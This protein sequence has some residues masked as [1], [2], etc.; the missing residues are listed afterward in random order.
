MRCRQAV[1]DASD[2]LPADCDQPTIDQALDDF[3]EA[4]RVRLAAT[5]YR[6][7]SDVVS[8]LRDALNNYSYQA[9]SDAERKRW[10]AAFEAGDEAA[11]CKLFG[12]EKIVAELG[13]FLDWF[14]VRKVIA[15]DDL[16]RA[17]GTVIKKLVRWLHAQGH[18]NEQDA[19]DAVERGNGAARDLP[20]ASRLTDALS[21]LCAAAP[22]IDVDDVADEDWV[23]DTLPITRIEAGKLWLGE[24]G[25]LKL[26]RRATDNARIG[27]EV[28]VVIAHH[29]G[30]WHLLENGFVYP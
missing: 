17:A 21:D 4:Q 11:F 7:Y 23:E 30:R 15:S 2:V 19:S 29:R 10:E 6:R 24:R 12:P 14:M 13:G 18:V 28:W 27:W 25:P 1:C 5:T 9:L 16:L 8:L 20:A 26:P 3:L 22:A